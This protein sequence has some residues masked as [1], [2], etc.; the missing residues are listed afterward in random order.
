MSREL[1]LNLIL[2]YFCSYDLWM[3]VGVVMFCG[4]RIRKKDFGIRITL[5]LLAMLALSVVDCLIIVN[6]RYYFN[7]ILTSMQGYV[8]YS[9]LLVMVVACLTMMACF[10]IQFLD[11]LFFTMSASCMQHCVSNIYILSFKLLGLEIAGMES[12]VIYLAEYLICYPIF[13][14]VFVRKL[15]HEPEIL[16]NYKRMMILSVVILFFVYILF[17]WFNEQF[18]AQAISQIMCCLLLLSLQFNL[19]NEDK[20]K[21]QSE[22]LQGILCLEQKQHA[23]TKETID[24]I[25]RKCHDLKHQVTMLRLIA[26]DEEREKYLREIEKAIAI[27]ETK[28]NTGND[29][30]DVVLM[31]KSL[32]CDEYHIK[33]E[34]IA[35][36]SLLNFMEDCDLPVLV[37]NALDN[38]IECLLKQEEAQKRYIGLRIIEKNNFISIHIE[39]YN[40][41]PISFDQAGLPIT[42]KKDGNYHGYGLKSIVYI[43]KKYGGVFKISNKDHLFYLDILFPNYGNKKKEGL[44]ADF[45]AMLPP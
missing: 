45:S 2:S 9:S 17:S 7:A 3:F 13:Y 8:I 11:I 35:D 16:S 4:T 15:Q 32:L 6:E 39:N 28:I 36:G 33:R 24:I 20:T 10:E 26:S 40:D 27:Y 18:F 1:I 23:L 19:F 43:V 31:E 30:L 12:L 21:R 37:G 22:M 42:T 25:N 5:S 14:F 29:I 34:I 38:A 41:T 44:Q